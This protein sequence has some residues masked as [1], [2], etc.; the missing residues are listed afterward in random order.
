MDKLWGI[1]IGLGILFGA[2]AIIMR[3]NI[4]ILSL[5]IVALVSLKII[6]AI[7]VNNSAKFLR[8]NLNL[9]VNGQLN[10]N[11][12]RSRIRAIN[13]I[14][15]KINEYLEKIRN[16]V[17]QYVNLSERTTK[18]SQS[19]K[20]QSESLK[21][22]SGEIAST[23]QNI[24]EAVNDQ[25]ESTS[26]VR[27]NMEV[28]IQGAEN[29]YENAKVSLEV[30]EG[31]K[32][33]VEESFE[34]F[35]EA[36]RKVEE[37]KDYNDKVLEDMMRL[38]KS[39]RQISA[40]TEAVEA[41]ASQTHLL[42][43]NASIEAARAGEAGRGFAVVAGEVSKL[44]DD[45]SSSAKEINDL[46]G[47]IIK[48]INGLTE[49]IKIQTEVISNNVIYANKALEKSSD[50]NNA[51]DK[52]IQAVDTI[53]NLTKGQRN[54]V[55]EINNAIAIINDATQQNAA[56]SEEISASTEEQLSI[57]ETMCESIVKLN[58]AIEY[59]NSI[60]ENFIKGFKITQD[61]QEKIDE[62][63]QFLEEV[64]KMDGIAHMDESSIVRILK[65]KQNTLDY[66]E[67]M[68]VIGK[69]GYI[70]G[71]TEKLPKEISDCSARPY[72][73]RAV[74]GETFVSKEY[75]STLTNNY[76]IT[77]AMPLFDNG[78]ID[79]VITADINLNKD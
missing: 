76:N 19:M 5:S 73:Q 30:A 72:F 63:K 18:E 2:L 17:G 47:E 14:A 61:I 21:V 48:E 43:L 79:G 6:L 74:A 45:S 67:L 32:T 54:Q 11:I 55:E 42:A 37:I 52:N 1:Y 71:A 10:I 13:L 50:I 39:I 9:I 25:A 7:V 78:R 4:I 28:F 65:E 31:S 77:V 29:I 68:V 57:T 12:R 51:V 15:E 8:Q 26:K 69:D 58:D 62:T 59:S 40:I 75:I 16:L 35:G 64:T 70:K 49:N 3:D 41:I 60:I 44:A 53:V 56:V 36:F 34:I 23:I 24:A 27:D 38:D 66:V 22:T 46:V 20:E 33:I